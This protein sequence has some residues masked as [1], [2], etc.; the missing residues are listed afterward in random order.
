[1]TDKNTQEP[2]HMV[3]SHGSD[4][5]EEISGESLETCRCQPEEYEVRTLYAERPAPIAVVLPAKQFSEVGEDYLQADWVSGWNACLDKVKEL[6][7]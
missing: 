3:R 2:V 4:C 7:Q 1:M 6:N 5:W